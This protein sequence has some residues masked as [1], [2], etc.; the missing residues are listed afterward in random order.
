[1]SLHP[2]AEAGDSLPSGAAAGPE[3]LAAALRLFRAFDAARVRHCHFKSNEHLLDGLAGLTDLDVLVDRSQARAVQ[4]VLHAVGYK[5]FASWFSAAYPAVEDYLGF[6]AEAGRLVH[7]HLHYAL[8]V[9]EKNLKG[10]HLASAPNV[11]D[12]RVADADTGVAICDPDHEMQ[13]LLLRFA[14]KLRWR[15][16]LYALLGRSFFRGGALREFRWLQSRIDRARLRRITAEE[17][18]AKAGDL[19]VGLA[20]APPSIRRLHA[21]RRAA[22]PTLARARTFGRL[23]AIPI[24]VARELH[25]LVAAFCRR[26]LGIARPLRRTN[27]TGGRIVAFLGPDGCGKSTL[28]RE[29]REWL[30]WK[31]DVHSV[32]FGS[33][34]GPSIWYVWVM[35][36]PLRVVRRTRRLLGREVAPVPGATRGEEAARAAARPSMAK[37]FWALALALEKNSKMGAAVAA[38][39][40]GM[41]VVCDRYPQVQVMG[42][43]DGPL[44]APWLESPSRLRRWIARFE[45][46]F[47]ARAAA[48]APD[49]VVKLDVSP[50]VALR[51]KPGTRFEVE[52]RRAALRQIEYGPG[53][54][55]LVIDASR[56]LDVVRLEVKRAI[57]D[58]L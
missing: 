54:E 31:L 22:R 40:R 5:R 15:D 8:V 38:R 19:V 29:I 13:L 57:W 52:R 51:R 3:P 41:V 1:M 17:Y 14:L 33:G 28:T 25:A 12:A 35:K 43:N 45:H 10:H 56:P 39:N 6:D 23:E 58:R 20:D 49:L 47:Y 34:D 2:H 16:S 48:A 7:L 53:S 46:T 50:E 18:G 55:S 11:L 9:G 24:R 21:L 36:L 26:K 30:S 42:Y 44:L 32:Y 4:G 27:P 37:A